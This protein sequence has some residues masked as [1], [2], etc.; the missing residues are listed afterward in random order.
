MIVKCFFKINQ[1]PDEDR[2][3]AADRYG[4]TPDDGE[5]NSLDTM[6]GRV[7]TDGS[8]VTGGY[9]EEPLDTTPSEN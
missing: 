5:N 1:N 6:D 9:H 4:L 8:S 2:G 3:H 7:G